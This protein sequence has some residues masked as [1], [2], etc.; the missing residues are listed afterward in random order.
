MGF[1]E[2]NFQNI[3]GGSDV[4]PEDAARLW[5][6]LHSLNRPLVSPATST[7]ETSQV[8]CNMDGFDWMDRWLSACNGNCHY[9]AVGMHS[10]SCDADEVNDLANRFAE[11]YGK[12]VWLSEFSCANGTASENLALAKA[13]LPKLNANPNVAR[14]FWCA[15][16]L[17][18]AQEFP[19]LVGSHLLEGH[20]DP[21]FEFTI[22]GEYFRDSPSGAGAEQI[23]V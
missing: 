3:G 2:P 9:D 10:Y 23:V 18:Q 16:T 5:P 14:Y 6:T 1:N 13:L 20:G 17:Q 8:G 7:C 12:P 21:P 4:S 11:R 15:T 22:V 19:F